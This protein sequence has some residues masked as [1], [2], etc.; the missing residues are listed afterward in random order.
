MFVVVSFCTSTMAMAQDY[1][2][3]NFDGDRQE[4]E[5]RRGYSCK[6]GSKKYKDYTDSP[7]LK[8]SNAGDYVQLNL[9]E[10]AKTKHICSFDLQA[11]EGNSS[12][13]HE[14]SFEVICDDNNDFTSPLQTFVY[15]KADLPNS[16]DFERKTYLIE[17][18]INTQYIKWRLASRNSIFIGLGNIVFSNKTESTEQP[19]ILKFN[20]TAVT[21]TIG[22]DDAAI[23]NFNEPSL[24]GAKTAVSYS[25]TNPSSGKMASINQEGEVT[26][27]PKFTGTAIIT[28]NAASATIN[29]V[30]YQAGSASYTITLQS[31]ED[32]TATVDLPYYNE[33]GLSNNT[34]GIMSN[35]ES[36][37]ESGYN[38][39]TRIKFN[40]TDNHFIIYL[41]TDRKGDYNLGFDLTTNTGKDHLTSR[42]QIFFAKAGQFENTPVQIYTGYKQ[43]KDVRYQLT[44]PEDVTAIKF[45]SII[46]STNLGIGAINIDKATP[47]KVSSLGYSTFISSKA[48]TFCSDVKVYTIKEEEGNIK[49]NPIEAT[50]DFKTV[51]IPANTGVVIE[52]KAGS[53]AAEILPIEVKNKDFEDNLLKGNLESTTQEIRPTQGNYIY[54]LNKDTNGKP[55]FYWAK[56][57]AGKYANLPSGRCYLDFKISDN[58]ETQG[59]SFNETITGIKPIS[60]SIPQNAIYNLSGRRVSQ[61]HKGIFILNGQKLI[62]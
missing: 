42:L 13:N 55:G 46:S 38:A 51:H 12:G 27:D 61:S 28:A 30:A 58:T 14:D 26:L 19:Q 2:R 59:F 3:F 32:N 57:S 16:I 18:P 17:I 52:A 20:P 60:P 8:L 41:P 10:P 47:V 1:S 15:K 11:T 34:K 50:Q 6:F 62:H 33:T 25:V 44:I 24:S 5:K 54:I 45:H 4:L 23:M 40:K 53:Y 29:G 49:L 39:K 7:K 22:K 31:L 9:Q 21:L 37:P 43:L 36:Y 35:C 56:G 48:A